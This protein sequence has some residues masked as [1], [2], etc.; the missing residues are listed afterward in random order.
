MD[1]DGFSEDADEDGFVD[2]HP[3]SLSSNS[4]GGATAA[5]EKQ[6]VAVK[7]VGDGRGQTPAGTYR[8]QIL[9]PQGI[10]Q[11]GQVNNREQQF[12]Q[13]QPGRS[14][15]GGQQQGQLPPQL[16]DDQI[17]QLFAQQ[18]GPYPGQQ[19]QYLGGG[20]GGQF[21]GAFPGGQF[22]GQQQPGFPQQAFLRPGQSPQSRPSLQSQ[23]G[24]GSF[25]QNPLLQGQYVLTSQQGGDSDDFS[26]GFPPQ[27]LPQGGGQPGQGLPPQYFQQQQPQSQ[28]RPLTNQAD[29]F[30]GQGF[31][32]S[33]GSQGLPPQFQGQGFS[34]QGGLPPQFQGQSGQAG[35]QNQGIQ[36]SGFP[37]DFNPSF[38]N[39]GGFQSLPQGFQQGSFAPP[40]F[41]QGPPPQGFASQFQQGGPTS[42]DGFS[43]QGGSQGLSQQQL[44]AILQAQQQQG[45]GGPQQGGPQGFSPPQIQGFVPGRFPTQGQYLGGGGGGGAGLGGATSGGPTS[46]LQQ[47]PSS[48]GQS[49]QL[50]GGVARPVQPA[51]SSSSSSPSTGLFGG[52][53]RKLSSSTSSKGEAKSN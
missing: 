43:P 38:G 40:G 50:G 29:Q 23:Q 28:Q 20:G 22:Q 26:A 1:L 17:Q 8:P 42:G 6:G 41:Q 37:F 53:E 15:F 11:G 4:K 39:Q 36:S 46:G 32:S 13:Q 5:Q 9:G 44:A 19:Q 27:F 48:S 14:P 33:Q 35:G 3:N 12:Q 18:Q 21:P 2:D 49:V 16:T 7:A 31:P 10:L 30:Q 24:G 34:S 47:S 25:Q 52:E 45:L 51:S